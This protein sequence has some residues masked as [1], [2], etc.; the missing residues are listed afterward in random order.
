MVLEVYVGYNEYSYI[1]VL[2]YN[3]EKKAGS[4]YTHVIVLYLSHPIWSDWSLIK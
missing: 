3:L 2:S 1:Y 4:V